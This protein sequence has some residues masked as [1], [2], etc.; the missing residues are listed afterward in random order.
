MVELS[1]ADFFTPDIPIKV[2]DIEIKNGKTIPTYHLLKKYEKMYPDTNFYFIVGTDLLPSL[3]T[4]DEGTKLINEMKF[5]I[6]QR[7]VMY[8]KI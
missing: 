6:F 7:E 8:Y 3:E 5:I 4:W 2:D 1:I